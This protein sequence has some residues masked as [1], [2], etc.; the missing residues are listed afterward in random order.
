[1]QENIE[2]SVI[3]PSYKPGKWIWECLESLI[4]QDLPKN[5]FEIIIVLNG[6]DEP[7]KSQINAYISEKMTSMMVRLIHV[8]QGG[9]SNARN[10]G[11]DC[12]RGTYLTF[13]D[14][15][16]YVSPSYLREMLE[17]VVIG[18]VPLT[19]LIAFYDGSKE[20]VSHFISRRFEILRRGDK[21]I[22]LL[23]AKSYMS[24]PVAKALAKSAVGN[25]RFDS[26]FKIGE[27]GLFMFGVSDKT[28]KFKLTSPNAIYYRR[29][30]EN[31]AMTSKRSYKQL[32]K[33][34]FKLMTAYTTIYLKGLPHYSFSFYMSRMA[35]AIAKVLGI[36]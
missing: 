30:R 33:N 16:D 31:S 26:R 13:I 6:C 10:V 27:D 23:Q 8:E 5:Q 14:D 12:T 28:K 4:N 1:M 21:D 29:Y 11:I 15:D 34:E 9:V 20:T 19:N 2:L 7:Y 18:F 35:V 24:V 32:L 36:I 3:I 22:S 25:H 17:I